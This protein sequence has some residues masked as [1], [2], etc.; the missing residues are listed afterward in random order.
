M[1][2]VTIR[3]DD[4]FARELIDTINLASR[5]PTESTRA[6][7]TLRDI[8]QSALDSIQTHRTVRLGKHLVELDPREVMAKALG[9]NIP[10]DATDD[11]NHRYD[12]NR[13]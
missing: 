9:Q 2:K 5:Y 12:I 11:L 4:S 13:G 1:A 7:L 6:A 3:I 10:D 8:L